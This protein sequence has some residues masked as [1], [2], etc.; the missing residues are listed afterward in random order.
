MKAR[1]LS[2]TFESAKHLA[3][4]ASSNLLYADTIGTKGYLHHAEKSG[5]FFPKTGSL[6]GSLTREMFFSA[7]E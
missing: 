3:R 1:T 5:P 2:S 4:K 7:M 6:G